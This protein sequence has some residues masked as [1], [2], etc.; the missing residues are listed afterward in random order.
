MKIIDT[1]SHIYSEEFDNDIEEVI[2]RAKQ[3]GVESIL[4]PNVDVDSIVRLHSIADRYTDYCIPMMGL[5]PTSIGEDWL[6]QLEIIK[7]QFSKRSYIAI[8]EIGLDL[9]W[10]RTYEKEQRQAFEEQ[11]R[12]SIEYDLPVAIHSR[13][14]ILECVEC[15]KNVGP[16]KLRG[17]FH[18]F[19]GSENELTEIL[20]LENFLLGINGVVTFK[21]STLSAVLKQT[22][23]SKIIVETDSPY[24]APVPYRGRRNESSYTIKVAEK[25]A[26][27]FGLSLNE[28]GEITTE[29][30]IKLFGLKK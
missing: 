18:S 24:L 19:G 29:N 27:I 30:A 3:V 9:Y 11:L 14:A 23:L 16:E 21:N 17:V 22:D 6:F 1:H 7:Q 28:V 5:H 12:W 8:G 2:L 4:L 10:D 25:L 26:E 15:I 13:D 20:G